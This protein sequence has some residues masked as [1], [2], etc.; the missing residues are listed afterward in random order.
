MIGRRFE[1]ALSACRTRRWPRRICR[2]VSGGG[3]R[4]AGHIGRE[5]TEPR[6]YLPVTGLH[7]VEALLHVG[8]VLAESREMAEWGIEFPRPR[9]DVDRL[10]SR[11]E[12]VIST[13]TGGLAQLAKRRGVSIVQGIGRFTGSNTLDVTLSGG[14]VQSMSFEHCILASGSRPAVIPAFNLPT[15]RV[16]DSTSALELAEIPESLL[17][18]GGGYI[19]LEMGTVYAEL[20]SRVTVVE[21]TETLLPGADRDL[22][23]PLEKRLSKL[24]ERI[25]MGTRVVSLEDR[26]NAIAV[27]FE[28]PAGPEQEIFSRVMVAVGRRPNSDGIGLENTRVTVSPK[29]F[30]EVDQRHARAIPR[31]SRSATSAES[32]CSHT[33]PVT[34]E[35][36]PWRSSMGSRLSSSRWRSRRLSSRTLRSPGRA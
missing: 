18:I 33:A 25:R 23:K 4:H 30:V 27:S 3:S 2:G 11:K 13:L 35:R 26:G 5:G 9:I 15:P 12:K 32:P 16:M 31:S 1:H 22:V 34:K 19:G 10:R 21:L 20:G 29:G 24:F 36:S 17:V 7:S 6:R 28:G 8:R 14:G